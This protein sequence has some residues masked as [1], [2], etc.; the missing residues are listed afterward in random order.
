MD[1]PKHVICLLG[2]VLGTQKEGNVYF[3]ILCL[4]TPSECSLSYAYVVFILKI[5]LKNALRAYNVRICYKKDTRDSLDLGLFA[6]V[7]DV[8]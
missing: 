3:S 4:S 5:K 8:W 2:E 7:S 6:D 1:T